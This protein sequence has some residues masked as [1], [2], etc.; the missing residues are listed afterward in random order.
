MELQ[1]A[2]NSTGTREEGN[3]L[4]I[5]LGKPRRKRTF[6]EASRERRGNVKI[7]FKKLYISNVN[8][9]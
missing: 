9:I 8:W 6:G 1:L 3:T 5:L 7:N 4:L 2:I